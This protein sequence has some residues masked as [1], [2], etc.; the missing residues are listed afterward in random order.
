MELV[1]VEN[2]FLNILFVII[3][4]FFLYLFT[5]IRVSFFHSLLSNSVELIVVDLLLGLF[6]QNTHLL[7]RIRGIATHLY[8]YY[9]F[10]LIR[11]KGNYLIDPYYYVLK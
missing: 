3:G 5:C 11:Q 4:L 2:E 9:C 8:F 6:I 10:L 1:P 7:K